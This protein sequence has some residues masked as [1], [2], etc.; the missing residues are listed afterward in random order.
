MQNGRL[1]AFYS[2]VNSLPTHIETKKNEDVKLEQQ[3][4]KALSPNKKGMRTSVMIMHDLT[5]EFDSLLH[6]IH[7][8][9]GDC[10]DF[11]VWLLN[12]VHFFSF[13]F[14]TLGTL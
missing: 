7:L 13:A 4:K 2:D 8:G 9:N 6:E 3:N 5:L 12:R 10:E 1:H 11:N 14:L